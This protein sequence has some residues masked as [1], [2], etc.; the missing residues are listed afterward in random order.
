MSTIRASPYSWVLGDPIIARVKAHNERGWSTLSIVGNGATVQTK[1]D[2]MSPCVRG[3]D[4]SESL[5][6]VTW[7][8]PTITGGASILSYHLQWDKGTSGSIW[9][10]LIGLSPASTA[11]FLKV[12]TGVTAGQ[13]YY[14]RVRA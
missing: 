1:P 4:T 6:H 11:L 5:L 2:T 14:F 7:S 3:S 12:T 10:D 8:A 9:Y 13:S